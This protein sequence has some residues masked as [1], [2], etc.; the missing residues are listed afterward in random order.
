MIEKAPKVVD[1]DTAETYL[2]NPPVDL[3]NL[4]KYFTLWGPGWGDRLGGDI[5]WGGD[6]TR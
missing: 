1:K 4:Q 5:D 2:G 6:T 3:A